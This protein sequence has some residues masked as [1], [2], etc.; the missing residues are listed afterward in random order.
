MCVASNARSETVALDLPQRIDASVAS[1][2]TDLPVAV[3]VAIVEA[4]PSVPSPLAIFVAFSGSFLW[5][6]ALTSNSSE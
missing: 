4:G 1:F 2:L 3:T 6:G 5:H